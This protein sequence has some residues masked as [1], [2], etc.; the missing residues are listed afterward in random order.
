[1][2]NPIT[3]YRNDNNLTLEA[4][5]EKFG[6]NKSTAMRWEEGQVPVDRVAEISAVTGILP[7]N[8]RPDIAVIF[9]AGAA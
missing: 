8:L 5:G 9:N 4:F 7:Q 2:S 3:Q 1:M 6:V